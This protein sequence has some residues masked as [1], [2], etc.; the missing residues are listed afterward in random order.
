RGAPGVPVEEEVPV[1]PEAR[2]PEGAQTRPQTHLEQRP[3]VR[4]EGDA[5]AGEDQRAECL[6]L[7]PR[8]IRGDPPRIRDPE[9]PQ[10]AA[11]CGLRHSRPR[12]QA[13]SAARAPAPAGATPRTAPGRA[14]AMRPG[15]P[16]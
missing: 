6:E 8:E 14:R 3:L 2:E 16:R 11:G 10:G 9:M 1:V 13:E 5:R 12:A 7:R 15:T 4:S